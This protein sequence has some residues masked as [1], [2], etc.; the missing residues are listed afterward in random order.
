MD[1]NTAI[2]VIESCDGFT[3]ESTPV[4][5]AWATVLSH[6][7]QDLYR[8]KCIEVDCVETPLDPSATDTEE[9]PTPDFRDICIGLLRS[10]KIQEAGLA[11]PF[12]ET[13][14]KQ[15]EEALK[16]TEP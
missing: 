16:L 14:I 7:Y 13:R 2:D 8:D 11:N 5:E 12:T 9:L 3:D 6:L 4:G 10:L 1:L 15:A